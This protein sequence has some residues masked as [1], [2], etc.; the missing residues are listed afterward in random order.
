MKFP[1]I[2][3]DVMEETLRFCMIDYSI[4]SSHPENVSVPFQ[5][6][7]KPDIA[8]DLMVSANFLEIER[9]RKHVSRMLAFYIDEVPKLD[10][11][12]EELTLEVFKNLD[13]ISL[14]KCEEFVTINTADI[15][16][17]LCDE[18]FLDWDQFPVIFSWNVY[19][20]SILTIDK[21]LNNSHQ[22]WKHLRLTRDVYYEFSLIEG[23][24]DNFELTELKT[25]GNWKIVGKYVPYT[26]L[27]NGYIKGALAC[28]SALSVLVIKSSSNWMNFDLG[29]EPL[30]LANLTS[31]IFKDNVVTDHIDSLIDILSG[32][33]KLE[34]LE[35]S[36]CNIEYGHVN[37]LASIIEDGHLKNISHLSLYENNIRA[38]GLNILLKALSNCNNMLLLDVSLNNFDIGNIT[39]ECIKKTN[40]R[41][42]LMAGNVLHVNSAKELTDIGSYLGSNLPSSLKSLCLDEISFVGDFFLQAT[43]RNLENRNISV[44]KLFLRGCTLHI[45]AIDAVLNYAS[46]NIVKYIDFRSNAIR[47][48]QDFIMAIQRF[49]TDGSNITHLRIEGNDLGIRTIDMIVE[50]AEN[51]KNCLQVLSLFPQINLSNQKEA[52]MRLESIGIRSDGTSTSENFFE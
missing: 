6:E 46:R 13:S 51:H 50:L 49:F 45:E 33:K 8:M 34:K 41:H 27:Q 4:N 25:P 52:A 37:K 26:I 18:K 24:Y 35:I 40:L 23:V 10:S 48:T 30:S 1:D 28:L 14:C 31:L 32:M 17:S 3:P 5:F 20:A 9:L 44:E 7:V 36:S 21:I 42:L 19:D 11:Y 47:G 16:K 39:W 12:P 15:W 43:L 38:K 29:S 22:P 2:D